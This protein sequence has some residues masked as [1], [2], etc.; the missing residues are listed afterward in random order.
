MN[1]DS[2]SVTIFVLRSIIMGLSRLVS[3]MTKKGALVIL[4]LGLSAIVWG[5]DRGGDDYGNR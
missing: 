2:A 5:T 3:T 4:C 1:V